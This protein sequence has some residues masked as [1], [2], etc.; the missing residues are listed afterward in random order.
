[1]KKFEPPKALRKGFVEAGAD[2]FGT[3]RESVWSNRLPHDFGKEFSL[4]RGTGK[5]DMKPDT[6]NNNLPRVTIFAESGPLAGDVAACLS[7]HFQIERVTGRAMAL[8]S[9]HDGCQAMLLMGWVRDELGPADADLIKQALGV[10][11]RVLVLGTGGLGLGPELDNSVI[12]LPSLPSPQVL[13]ENLNG[14]EPGQ[15]AGVS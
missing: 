11:C 13:F 15:R 5:T 4:W 3:G 2:R 9:L 10:K 12:H 14:L 6:D 7:G 1:M 8:R